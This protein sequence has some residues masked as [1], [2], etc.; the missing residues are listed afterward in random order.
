MKRGVSDNDQSDGWDM[1]DGRVVRVGVPDFDHDQIL[2]FEPDTSCALLRR[3]GSLRLCLNRRRRL[4]QS[5]YSSTAFSS[6]PFERLEV[7]LTNLRNRATCSV[8]TPPIPTI[9]NLPR[10]SWCVERRQICLSSSYVKY[11]SLWSPARSVRPSS[12]SL[13]IRHNS[14]SGMPSKSAARFCVT[15]FVTWLSMVFASPRKQSHGVFLD[16]QK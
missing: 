10:I 15:Y 6:L 14:C 2:S 4:G 11:V 3:S 12:N 13:E 7:Y 8:S 16:C 9:Q 1:Q 5:K